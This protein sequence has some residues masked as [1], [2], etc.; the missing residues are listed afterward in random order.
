MSGS[1]KAHGTSVTWWRR[2]IVPS[3]NAT[4]ASAD[5]DQQVA[6]SVGSSYQTLNDVASNRA[7]FEHSLRNGSFRVQ[8]KTPMNDSH[9]GPESFNHPANQHTKDWVGPYDKHVGQATPATGHQQQAPREDHPAGVQQTTEVGGLAKAR[10]PN[11]ADFDAVPRVA[12]RVNLA[13]VSATPHAGHGFDIPSSRHQA[14]A[15]IVVMP[16]ADDVV[17]IEIVVENGNFGLAQFRSPALL[18]EHLPHGDWRR[19]VQ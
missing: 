1:D 10:A 11:A 13:L 17:G 4:H 5:V 8:V 3:K 19:R 7:F 16:G 9:G 14:F 2:R 12:L 6:G 18:H 15:Q